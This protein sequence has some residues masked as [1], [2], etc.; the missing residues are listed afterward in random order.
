MDIQAVSGP[1][2]FIHDIRANL[3]GV[4][5]LLLPL[6]HLE[7][8]RVHLLLS[9]LFS[10]AI[11]LPLGVLVTHYLRAHHGDHQNLEGNIFTLDICISTNFPIYHIL[12]ATFKTTIF[13][14]SKL[15]Q[16]S[17]YFLQ[18]I[19]EK[20]KNYIP[21]KLIFFKALKMNSCYSRMRLY[22]ILDSPKF[23]PERAV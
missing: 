20:V 3:S 15:S 17:A 11:H 6:L 4:L 22:L 16:Y 18:L 10:P 12:S 5:H 14:N 9:L 19:E 23:Y 2:I 13:H 1:L 21:A 8:L 7:I